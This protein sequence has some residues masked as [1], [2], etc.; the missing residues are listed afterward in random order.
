MKRILAY[1]T[2]LFL[3]QTTISANDQ[4]QVYNT[5]V[6]NLIGEWQSPAWSDQLSESW[7]VGDDNWLHQQAYYFEQLDTT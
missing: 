6:K 2:V 7:Q 1:T 5:L 3:L 4:E